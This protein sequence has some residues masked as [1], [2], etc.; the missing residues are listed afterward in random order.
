MPKLKII[1]IVLST[2]RIKRAWDNNSKKRINME[3]T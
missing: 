3:N 2:R 1:F